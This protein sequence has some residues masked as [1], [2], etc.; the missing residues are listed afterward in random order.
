MR[1][2]QPRSTPS[3]GSAKRPTLSARMDSS[4]RNTSKRDWPANDSNTKID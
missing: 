1:P 4:E 2:G 3:A